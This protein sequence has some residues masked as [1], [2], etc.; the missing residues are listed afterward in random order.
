[1]EYSGAE[2]TIWS[3]FVAQFGE[4]F[5]YS[6]SKSMAYLAPNRFWKPGRGQNATRKQTH[7]LN[8]NDV[9]PH[10]GTSR[11][12]SKTPRSASAGFSNLRLPPCGRWVRTRRLHILNGL[13]ACKV[14]KNR[15]S[16]S[17]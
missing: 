3:L 15:H 2:R 1:M 14:S 12:A 11:T 17:V 10:A 5:E 13:I 8:I 4:V 16:G 6:A 9:T 7:N